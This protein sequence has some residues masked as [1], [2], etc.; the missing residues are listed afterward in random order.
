MVYKEF[1]KWAGENSWCVTK[2]N[3]NKIKLDDSFWDRYTRIPQEYLEFI[4]ELNELA[5]PND[6]TWFLCESDYNNESES[7]YKWNEFELLELEAAEGDNELTNSIRNWWGEYFP[8]MLSVDGYYS[9]YAIHL[10]KGTVVRGAEPEFEEVKV[11]ANN[12]EDF[13]MKIKEK[14]IIIR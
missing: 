6:T 10:Q 11:V 7:D 5:S 12:F 14:R 8:I 3:K 1:I 9:F 13:L 4:E 2:R